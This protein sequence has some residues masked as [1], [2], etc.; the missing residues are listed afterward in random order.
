MVKIIASGTMSLH[1]S[2]L[3]HFYSMRFRITSREP[4]MQS[5]VVRNG[6]PREKLLRVGGSSLRGK[7][8]RRKLG[9]SAGRGGRREGL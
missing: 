5:V 6:A 8:E 7:L 4:C 1:V 3:L 2:W 9:G